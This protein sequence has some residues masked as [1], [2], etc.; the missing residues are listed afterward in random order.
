MSK[1]KFQIGIFIVLA[2]IATI[3]ALRFIHN[4]Y[5][6]NVVDIP[7]SSNPVPNEPKTTN[8]PED[9]DPKPEIVNPK[10]SLLL[11]VPFTSQA[12]TANWDEL[13]NEACEEA[14]SIMANEYF[15]G[16]KNTTL[17][18][19]F[20]EGEISKLTDW[21][22]KNFGYH[23]SINT[24]E[25]V[26]M[27]KEVYGLNAEIMENFNVDTIKKA[28]TEGKLI[29][30]P[31]N[32]RLLGN[33]NF[34]SPGPIYHMLVIRGY[35]SNSIITNDPGTRKGLNYPYTFDVLYN[36]NGDYSHE[37]HEVDLSKKMVIAVWK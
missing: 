17:A 27:I 10:S 37:T 19:A 2:G 31:A 25:T 22:D 33:P 23:L 1:S 4:R 26:R 6:N 21:Q 18:P 20:V 15:S 30:V 28:L 5:G 13:H 9:K 24:Q 36:A 12:P 7:K 34:K 32:G 8:K 16:N 11:P 3:F 35:T 14:S 29:L